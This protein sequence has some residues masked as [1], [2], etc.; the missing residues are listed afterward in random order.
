MTTRLRHS[1]KRWSDGAAVE[2]EGDGTVEIGAVD[3]DSRGL[4]TGENV[5]FRQAEGCVEAHRNHRV[6][7]LYGCEEFWRG[8]CGAAVMADF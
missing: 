8:G 4:E 3:M 2:V 7:G 6:D 1:R 5:G